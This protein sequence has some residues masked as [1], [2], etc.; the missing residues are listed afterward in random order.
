MH[1]FFEGDDLLTA[2]NRR[3]G[4][5]IGN[6]REVSYIKCTP[7]KSP[8]LGTCVHLCEMSRRYNPRCDS[9]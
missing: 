5:P 1:E 4:I 2:L 6:P 3:R 9:E 7:M 8:R